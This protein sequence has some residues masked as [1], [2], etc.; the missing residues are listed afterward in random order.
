MTKASLEE[1]ANAYMRL[2]NFLRWKHPEILEEFRRLM[3][4]SKDKAIGI[5]KASEEN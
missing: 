5:C 2:Y 3:R 1:K 4:E